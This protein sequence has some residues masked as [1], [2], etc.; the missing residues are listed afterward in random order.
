[1]HLFN[2][3][4]SGPACRHVV[5]TT[6][7]GVYSGLRAAWNASVVAL[8]YTAESPSEWRDQFDRRRRLYQTEFMKFW[9]EAVSACMRQ[10][11]CTVEGGE[12]N[13]QAASAAE[14]YRTVTQSHFYADDIYSLQ[15]YAVCHTMT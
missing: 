14:V 9:S 7:A 12:F 6:S 8:A 10:S 1:M 15:L 3:C 2:Q 5:T 4:A 13:S 11:A